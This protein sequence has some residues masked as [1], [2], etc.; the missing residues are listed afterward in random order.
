MIRPI[1]STQK[2][3]FKNKAKMTAYV[4]AI[5]GY[6]MYCFPCQSYDHTAAVK[7][8]HFSQNEDP[9]DRSRRALA[10]ECPS[11]DEGTSAPDSSTMVGRRSTMLATK[12]SLE[13]ARILDPRVKKWNPIECDDRMVLP[14]QLGI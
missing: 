13:C 10:N 3:C 12:E 11:M 1:S 8:T 7:K 9:P 5:S 4:W 14:F 2:T 6:E